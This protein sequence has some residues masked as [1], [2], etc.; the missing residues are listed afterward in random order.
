MGGNVTL[1]AAEILLLF[2]V[3]NSCWILPT[4]LSSIKTGRLSIGFKWPLLLI[5]QNK[6]YITHIYSLTK[7]F[8]EIK[9]NQ[10]ANQNPHILLLTSLS[11][12]FAMIALP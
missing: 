1:L 2:P 11:S 9:R 7:A 4:A 12:L 6:G 5:S 10:A 8:A 3:L